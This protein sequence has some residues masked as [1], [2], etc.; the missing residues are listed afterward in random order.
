VAYAVLL[1]TALFSVLYGR[2]LVGRLDGVR[3]GWVATAL[4][5]VKTVVEVAASFY[6]FAYLFNA[7]AY[8]FTPRWRRARIRPSRATPAVGLLYLCCDDLDEDA[9][10]S[11]REL[12]YPGPLYLILHD[13][14]SCAETREALNALA[15]SFRR[16]VRWQV[17]VLRRPS[18]TGG[19]P[20]A[21]N[22]VLDQTAHLYEYFL[23]LDNDS[24][25]VDRKMI[26][27]ILPYFERPEVAAVQCRP[28][29]AESA[30][31]CTINRLLAR[32]IGAFHVILS[33][34]ARFGWVPFVGH[35]A[36][37]RTRH[38]L[39]VGGMTPG[40]FSDDLDLTVRLNLEGLSVVYA[41]E[42][43]MAEKHPPHY[44]AFRKRS[45]KWAFGCMQTLKRHSWAVLTSGRFT[46]AQQVSF[47]QFVGF[48]L[49]Q[50]VLLLYLVVAFVLAPIILGP[51]ALAIGVNA[52]FGVLL[53]LLVYLP[54]LA[55]FLTEDRRPGWIRSLALCG[56]VYGGADFSVARG[57]WDGLW[58][59][60]RTWIP[61]NSV[62]TGKSGMRDAGEALFGMALLC[63]PFVRFP[64]LLYIPSIYLFAGK[65][66]F[67]PALSILYDDPGLLP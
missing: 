67:G 37:L 55:Y 2:F 46:L 33:P 24:T 51:Y 12:D 34:C 4:L 16:W 41:S 58:Y 60:S 57:V 52:V 32:A 43:Y 20:G 49:M 38:V 28:V 45:Y 1:S 48:Y 53:I 11:L 54:F 14:S 23:L 3:L 10:L 17:I 5:S 22:Y 21:I 19:K 36:M 30:T 26:Q 44:A 25:V 42:I 63:G 47:F 35:N 59:R 62:A 61:T 8:L 29:A 40:F 6:A 66:L 15:D 64:A 27:R 39:S 56:L 65:F 7:M 9:L 18:R 13:D 50:A 31:Y